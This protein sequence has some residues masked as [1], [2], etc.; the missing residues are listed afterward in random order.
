MANLK[1]PIQLFGSIETA[2]GHTEAMLCRDLDRPDEAMIQWYGNEGH[3]GG[4]RVEMSAQGPGKY[5]LRP[6]LFF[7]PDEG[8]GLHAPSHIP[9]SEELFQCVGELAQIRN[10][11]VGSWSDHT[12][13]KKA[14]EFHPPSAQLRVR[15]KKL[16]SWSAFKL[17]AAEQRRKGEFE[18]FRGHGSSNFPL[19]STL[20]RAGRARVERFC[21]ETMPRFHGFAEAILDM[22]F[23]PRNADDFS[24]VLG[25]A[26][27]HGLPTPLLD[28]TA[29]PYVAAFF[30]FSDALEN[31]QTR[32]QEHTHVRIFGLSRQVSKYANPQVSLT[33]PEP[34]ASY[35]SISPRKNPRLLAQQGRFLVTNVE[36]LE[37]WIC[38]IEKRY[39]NK[40]IT[41]VDI[42][43][44]FASEALEDLHYMGLSGATMF[45]GLDGVCRMMKH[46]MVY[47]NTQIDPPPSSA[48]PT[49]QSSPTEQNVTVAD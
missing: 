1:L 3:A 31:K 10:K 48:M 35:L 2:T 46:E 49:K 42:P 27:H 18:D 24:V 25:L 36:D 6:L 7:V 14:F 12:G 29:S 26:Q 30:A 5:K 19:S 43:I 9:N 15:A 22:R 45:P 39:G 38:S 16:R 37:G 44:E 21:Y 4:V 33:W 8:G 23:T 20:H 11:F 32:L 47:K 34:H 40:L 28:W 41:A 13:Q 17:W